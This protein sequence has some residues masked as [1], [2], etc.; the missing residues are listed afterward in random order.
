MK[1]YYKLALLVTATALVV[2]IIMN[3]F[4][5][6]EKTEIVIDICNSSIGQVSFDVSARDERYNWIALLIEHVDKNEEIFYK[7]FGGVELEKSTNQSFVVPFEVCSNTSQIVVTID[8]ELISN[9][10]LNPE[11]KEQLM[12]EFD[13]KISPRTVILREMRIME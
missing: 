6:E 2:S 9:K 13:V 11:F 10:N 5:K 1:K 3:V 8:F 12:R 7:T 4:Q